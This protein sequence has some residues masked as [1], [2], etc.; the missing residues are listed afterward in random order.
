MNK[1]RQTEG[2]QE[3]D[4]AG[5]VDP[6]MDEVREVWRIITKSFINFTLPNTGKVIKSSGST[7]GI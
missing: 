3:C 1:G 6:Y 5:M 2:F 4:V 7:Q